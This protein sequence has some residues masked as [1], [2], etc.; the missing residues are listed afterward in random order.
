MIRGRG[1]STDASWGNR[2]VDSVQGDGQSMSRERCLEF[3]QWC[4]GQTDA[5]RRM[6]GEK[7]FFQLQGVF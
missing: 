4:T 1:A 2:E 5:D 3:R 6:E 7:M